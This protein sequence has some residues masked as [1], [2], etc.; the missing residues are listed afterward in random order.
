VKYL[1]VDDLNQGD[2]MTIEDASKL[3]KVEMTTIRSWIKSAKLRP[4]SYPRFATVGK[5]T[6]ISKKNFTQFVNRMF[7]TRK[8]G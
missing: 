1:S 2:L 6:F 3:F 8:A 7:E 5:T 4:E